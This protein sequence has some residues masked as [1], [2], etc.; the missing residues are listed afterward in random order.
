MPPCGNGGAIARA[1]LRLPRL[2]FRYMTSMTE[3]PFRGCLLQTGELV[4]IPSSATKLRF[5]GSRCQCSMQ[6]ILRGI[7]IVG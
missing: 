1:Y 3:T 2:C 4:R 7:N 5:T 6:I